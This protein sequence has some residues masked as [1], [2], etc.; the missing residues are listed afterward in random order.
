MSR[1]IY[2]RHQRRMSRAIYRRYQWRMSRAIYRRFIRVLDDRF[3]RLNRFDEMTRRG[4]WINLRSRDPG[5]PVGGEP[6]GHYIW[7]LEIANCLD[8][9]V[10]SSSQ[11]GIPP[12]TQPVE[13]L[14]PD[15]LYDR[16]CLSVSPMMRACRC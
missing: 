5:K 15:S 8:S 10:V 6:A 2:R 4:H 7:I 9:I 12:G 11:P 14:L 1:A 13:V 16:V 3:D